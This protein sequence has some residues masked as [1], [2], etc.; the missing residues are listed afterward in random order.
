MSFQMFARPGRPTFLDLPWHL[1]LAEW[2]SDELVDVVRGIGRHVV[3]FVSRT[4]RS[5][6]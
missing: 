5:T 6:R 2:D 3:R 4:A 1:P